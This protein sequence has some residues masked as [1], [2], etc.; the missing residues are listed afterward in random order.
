MLHATG[1]RFVNGAAGVDLF[2]VISGFIM[3]TIVAAQPDRTP[4]KFLLDRFWRIYPLWWIA[5]VPWI[6]WTLP[7]WQRLTTSITLWPI[8]GTWQTPALRVGWTLSFEMLF[9]FAVAA[10]MRVG[11]KPLLGL[12]AVM[13]GGGWCCAGRSSTISATR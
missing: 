1:Q 5:V 3:A 7:D 11:V 9:Y 12:F 8:F 13:L 2:F 10:S 4:Q 6:L